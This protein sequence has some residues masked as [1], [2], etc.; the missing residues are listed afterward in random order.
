[1]NQNTKIEEMQAEYDFSNGVQGKHHNAFAK[2]TNIILL[3]AD[4]MKHF[5][6]SQSVNHALR[7]LINLAENE[8][9]PNQ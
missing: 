5:K 4:V 2:G 9:S 7:M 8:I 6:D 3:D 1:M